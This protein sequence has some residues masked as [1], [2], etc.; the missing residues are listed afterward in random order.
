[1]YISYV[2][3]YNSMNHWELLVFMLCNPPRYNMELWFPHPRHTARCSWANS[4]WHC[5]QRPRSPPDSWPLW[6][7][8]CKELHTQLHLSH[9]W[10]EYTHFLFAGIIQCQIFGPKSDQPKLAIPAWTTLAASA[11]FKQLCNCAPRFF[12]W[13]HVFVRVSAH[14]RNRHWILRHPFSWGCRECRITKPHQ[15]MEWFWYLNP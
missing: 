9:R 13:Q 14:S 7:C 8:R 4:P 6:R 5:V 2:C 11:S 3:I 15:D 1:M 10:L 12:F